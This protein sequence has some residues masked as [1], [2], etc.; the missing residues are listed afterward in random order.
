MSAAHE[1]D[2]SVASETVSEVSEDVQDQGSRQ[3]T[4]WGEKERRRQ[5]SYLVHFAQ[6]F[7]ERLGRVGESREELAQAGK[8]FLQKYLTPTRKAYLDKARLSEFRRT[9]ELIHEATALLDPAAGSE[10]AA[11]VCR[12]FG[13]EFPDISGDLVGLSDVEVIQVVPRAA[14]QWLCDRGLFGNVQEF[15]KHEEISAQLRF[16]RVALELRPM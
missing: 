15:L 4:A 5:Q 10:L 12:S 16:K 1:V 11:A 14:L 9:K 13:E 6:R 7:R 8:I 2:C 3:R